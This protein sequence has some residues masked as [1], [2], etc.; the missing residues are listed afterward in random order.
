MGITPHL[1]LRGTKFYFRMAVPIHLVKKVGRAEVSTSLRTVHRKE[2]TLRCR[3]LSNSLD[4]F[5]Q[6]LGMQ[7]GPSIENIDAEIKAYFQ[8]ALNWS[9]EYTEVLMDDATLDADEEAAAGQ[10]G[11]SVRRASNNDPPMETRF[12]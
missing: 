9:L 8:R 10:N 2:A 7:D 12:A 6:R 3:Y 11:Q 1:V 4:V 5:F